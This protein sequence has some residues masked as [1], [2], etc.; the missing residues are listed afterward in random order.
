MDALSDGFS[1]PYFWLESLRWDIV[2]CVFTL[3]SY[4]QLYTYLD[5]ADEKKSKRT[6]C[7]QKRRQ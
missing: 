4:I 3:L 7:D 5:R 6:I 2:C 1:S